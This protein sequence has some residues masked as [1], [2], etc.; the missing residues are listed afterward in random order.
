MEYEI[1]KIT[2]EEIPECADV[3]RRSF[4]TAAEEFGLTPLNCA[5]NGAFIE[6]KRLFDDFDNG[7]IMFAVKVNG[8]TV[9]FTELRRTDKYSFELEKLGTLPEH[10]H[11]GYGRV[12]LEKA[13]R[14]AA[15]SGAERLTVG[16]IEKNKKLKK[17]YIANGFT[18]IGTHKFENLPFLVGFLQITFAG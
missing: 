6:D 8:V 4:A 1:I 5:T 11:N 13:K 7:N 2:R 15:E 14:T 3:V 12:L 16:I 9:A 10:R 17:W 18:H